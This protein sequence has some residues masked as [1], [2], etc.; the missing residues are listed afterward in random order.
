MSSS[1]RFVRKAARSIRALEEAAREVDERVRRRE[2][3]GR[4]KGS[5]M[6]TNPKGDGETARRRA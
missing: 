3:G 5:E 4:G 6:A 1:L 2:G